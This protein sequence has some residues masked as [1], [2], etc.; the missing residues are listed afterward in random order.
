MVGNSRESWNLHLITS[1][2]IFEDKMFAFHLLLINRGV[3]NILCIYIFRFTNFSYAAEVNVKFMFKDANADTHLAKILNN[4][5]DLMWESTKWIGHTTSS[6]LTWSY[7]PNHSCGP[8]IERMECDYTKIS[9]CH[10]IL[11][12]VK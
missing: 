10:K 4:W 8:W 12:K 1:T 6:L 11:I 9:I 7:H 5:F 3:E 2:D